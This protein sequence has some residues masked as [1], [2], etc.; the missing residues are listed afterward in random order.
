[1]KKKNYD[2]L[3]FVVDR[4]NNTFMA[5]DIGEGGAV[6]WI[7]RVDA[8]NS[9]A[10]YPKCESFAYLRTVKIKVPLATSKSR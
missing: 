7:S 3:Y 1:M 8:E 9:I 10:K 5:E 4:R 6:A 2:E